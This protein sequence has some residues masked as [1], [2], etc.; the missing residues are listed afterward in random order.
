MKKRARTKPLIILIGRT[1]DL[2]I[3]GIKIDH[4]TKQILKK[5]WPGPISIVL[6]RDGDIPVPT[7]SLS[8]ACRLPKTVWLR[9]LL[10]KK[11]KIEKFMCILV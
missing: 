4:R 9:D 8:L 7:P 10:K 3:F 6:P 11:E 1:N 2:K 5:Y